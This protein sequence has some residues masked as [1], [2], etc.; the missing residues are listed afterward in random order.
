MLSVETL[1]VTVVAEALWH[2]VP[3]GTGVATLELLRGLQRRTD[4]ALDAVCANRSQEAVSQSPVEVR[5]TRLPRVALY[6]AWA[7][8]GRP[9]VSGQ[10]AQVIHSPMLM[11]PTSSTRPVVVTVHDLAW[12]RRPEDFPRRALELYRRMWKRVSSD[13]AHIICSSQTTADHA[14]SAGADADQVSVV[15]LGGRNLHSWP[16]SV[17][18]S[19]GVRSP[20]ILSVGTAEPRKNLGRLLAAFEASELWR[21]GVQLAIVGPD[22]WRFELAASLDGLHPEARAHVVA[23]GQVGDA[24]LGALYK[25]ATA[26]AYPSLLEGFGLPVLEALAAGTPVL[27]SS[28]T[29]TAEI[30]GD[31][32]VLVDPTSVPDIAAGLKRIVSDDELR[33]TLA[34]AAP[35]QAER[36][37]WSRHLDETVAIYRGVAG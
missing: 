9:D 25:H 36:F 37:S 8:S 28:T 33:K 11:A 12:L 2:R 26:F 24:Q 5:R 14:A 27:T 21:D 22:G 15:Y 3:G 7:R 35:G 13:A 34:A 1:R 19:F 20:Y 32:G 30:A 18:G 16:G 31:A 6:E 17:S 23:I 10:E 29:A 4:V